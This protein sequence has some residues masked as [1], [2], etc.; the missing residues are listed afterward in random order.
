M[1]LGI[2]LLICAFSR[3]EGGIGLGDGLDF[4]KDALGWREGEGEEKDEGD[5]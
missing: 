4:D 5:G 3:W 2:G 1:K